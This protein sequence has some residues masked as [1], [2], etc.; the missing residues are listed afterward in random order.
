M[1]SARSGSGLKRDRKAKIGSLNLKG[2]QSPK[3]KISDVLEEVLK[4]LYVLRN[5]IVHGGTT[6]AEGRGRSQV[7]DGYRIMEALMPPILNI[8]EED[9]RKTPDSRYSTTIRITTS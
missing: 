6:F 7:K 3:G 9:I 1:Y 8:M 4:R 2:A 5:Q